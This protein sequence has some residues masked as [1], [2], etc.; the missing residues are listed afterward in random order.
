MMIEK[1]EK[2]IGNPVSK[3]LGPRKVVNFAKR[4]VIRAKRNEPKESAIGLLKKKK[5]YIS[6]IDKDDV[7]NI[8]AGVECVE[9]L[10]NFY[11]FAE[12]SS[13]V[14]DYMYRQ[15]EIDV[16]MRLVLVY[17][18]IGIQ[19]EL[20][21]P[22][23]VLFLTV[24]IVDRYLELNLVAQKDFLLLGLSAML[25][26]GKYE[27]DYP[28]GVEEYVT[29]AS[30]LYN[31]EHILAMEKS[32][33][34]TLGW[35]LTVP[36]TYHFLVRFVKAAGAD[37][38]MEDT[39]FYMAE[40]GLMHYAMMIKYSPSILAASSVY[41]AKLHLKITPI[42]NDSLE[43]HTGFSE[44]EVIECAQQLASF[45]SEAPDHFRIAYRKYISRALT[46]M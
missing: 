27:E 14:G 8:L 43:L 41:A 4:K 17:W 25:I 23:E 29:F 30:G 1:A 37:K 21:F 18:L 35:T 2:K 20:K 12:T 16:H 6:E 24:H 42:W 3:A 26:A 39:A 13:R 10:Y 31:R 34:E 33:L 46:L 9:D 15:K 40:L 19:L 11:K 38:E 44:P 45:H 32:V 5:Y 7:N 22:S 28:P 36:N